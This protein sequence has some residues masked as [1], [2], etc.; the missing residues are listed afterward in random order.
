MAKFFVLLPFE[1]SSD[2]QF[3]LWGRTMSNLFASGGLVNTNQSGTINWN[4]VQR[5]LATSQSVGYEIWAFNDSLQTTAPVYFKIEYGSNT[6][7]AQAPQYRIT[8]GT[9][10]DGSGSLIGVQHTTTRGFGSQA[11]ISGTLFPCFMSA[12]TN[13]VTCA[14]W[15]GAG[16]NI[17]TTFGIERSKDATG[18]DTTSSIYFNSYANNITNP[19]TA[20]CVPFAGGVPVAETRWAAL[21]PGETTWLASSTFAI[22]PVFQLLGSIQS[23]G[24]NYFVCAVNDFQQYGLVGLMP[25]GTASNYLRLTDNIK[26]VAASNERILMRYD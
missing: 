5:P 2:S 3:R 21:L 6:I 26:P 8:V 1:N 24:K 4:T 9:A 16:G 17:E 23:P 10:H 25:Y 14:M 18:A 11:S 19:V 15:L 20:W 13:R 22:S 7:Q 12:D